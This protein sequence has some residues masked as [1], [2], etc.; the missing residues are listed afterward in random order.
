[1]SFL[2]PSGKKPGDVVALSPEESRHLFKVL[3][4]REGDPVRLTDG[5][6]HL[7][8]G[9][10]RES[11]PKGVRVVLLAEIPPP[12]SHGRLAFAQALLKGDK[13]ESILQKAVELGAAAFLPFVSS[14]TVAE[15]KRGS[16]KLK[17][18]RKI[19]QEASKQC[20][21]AMHMTV[22]EPRTFEDLVIKAEADLKII[23]WEESREQL[24]AFAC[25]GA[26]NG[27]P[28]KNTVILIGPEGGFSREEA[29]LAARHGFHALSLGPLVL[30]VE[31]AAVTAISLIQYEL[32]NI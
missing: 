14:R 10:V 5:G 24:K 15:W 32:G 20:G 2:I 29:D 8:A 26:M 22:E 6:G 19:A 12:R 16:D 28:T 23:F 7:F 3:R 21:R 30:R 11:S 27:A 1:M 17:R 18:W 31:T 4:L 25:R 9:E 13:M